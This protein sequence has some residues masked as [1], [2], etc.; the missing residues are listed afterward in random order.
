MKS[1]AFLTGRLFLR[2]CSVK[3]QF[4]WQKQGRNLVK[5]FT[6]PGY[7]KRMLAYVIWLKI[8][9]ILRVFAQDVPYSIIKAYL[10]RNDDLSVSVTETK[11]IGNAN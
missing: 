10:H 11:P 7:F 1:Q 8:P 3:F 5:T 4:V 9:K 2:L 6:W